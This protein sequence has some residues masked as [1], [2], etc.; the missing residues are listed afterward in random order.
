MKRRRQP[1]VDDLSRRLDVLSAGA[2]ASLSPAE[3][4][5]LAEFDRWFDETF[6]GQIE[7]W[8]DETMKQYF[9]QARGHDSRAQRYDELR[10]RDLSP[11]RKDADQRRLA[12][13]LGVEPSEVEAYLARTIAEL[14]EMNSRK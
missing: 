7:A 10:Q 1:T 6:P 13:H 3:A 11:E 14:N 12:E 9:Q 4:R 2:G 5:E 8:S